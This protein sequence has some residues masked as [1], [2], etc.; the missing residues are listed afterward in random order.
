MIPDIFHFVFLTFGQEKK[1]FG[2]THFLAIKSAEIVNK[3]E[4]IFFHYN[5][6]PSGKWWERA[7]PL[8]T[9]NK[10]EPPEE[11]F[12]RKLLHPAHKADVIRLRML[13]EFGGVYLDMD[14]IC[15]KPLREFYNVSFAMGQ[16][17]SSP[18]YYGLV[19]KVVKSISLRTLG[20]F[21]KPRVHGLCNGV[22]FSE[23]DSLFI[24]V[25][26]DSYRTFRS[27]GVDEYWDEHSIKIP[28]QLSHRY[29]EMIT[30]FDPFF[31]HFPLWDSEGLSLLF[32]KKITF[33]KA[34]I[35][36]I[37]ESKSWERYLSQ[38]SEKTILEKDTTY[39]LIARRYLSS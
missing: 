15:V 23:K 24:T 31:F 30:Q 39:N 21:K 35:H 9:M 13:K 10:I 1:Q 36:H 2:L 6:E 18:A 25:W 29:P 17:L 20:P 28:Y 37:W 11:I 38:L 26:L 19:T 34:Y 4:K 33:D 3:P 22:L 5:L 16:Q 27:R 8:L 12:G 7:K 14:T 32:E